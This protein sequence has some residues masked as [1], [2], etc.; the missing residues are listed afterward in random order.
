MKQL[1]LT[2]VAAAIFSL[3][4]ASTAQAQAPAS[5]ATPEITVQSANADYDLLLICY[6]SE[7][8]TISLP[9]PYFYIGSYIYPMPQCKSGRY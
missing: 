5:Q 1:L 2:M 4:L 6:S 9:S 7:P 3:G 8:K